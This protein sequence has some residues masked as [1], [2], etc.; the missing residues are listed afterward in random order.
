MKNKEIL[1]ILLYST[2]VIFLVTIPL[3]NILLM[4]K[5]TLIYVLFMFLPFLPF[6]F[7]TDTTFVEKFLISNL[8]GLS[9]AFVYVILDVILKIPLTKITY[10][11]FT[12]IVGVLSWYINLK[13]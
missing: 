5:V 1:K 6:T 11:I 2:F 3:K 12:L 4:I 13:K 7:K 10:F 9:Y 8:L